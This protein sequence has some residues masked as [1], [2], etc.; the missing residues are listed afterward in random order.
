MRQVKNFA[1]T[2]KSY[3]KC[4]SELQTQ[5]VIGAVAKVS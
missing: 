4:L 3:I 2:E 5:E 1:N